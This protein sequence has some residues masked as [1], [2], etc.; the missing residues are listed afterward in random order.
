MA[1]YLLFLCFFIQKSLLAQTLTGVVSDARQRPLE[2]AV[3]SLIRASDSTFVKA[4]VTE[5]NGKFEFL[6]IKNGQYR[7]VATNVGF[8]RYKSEVIS[9]ENNDVTL[10]PI[11][12]AEQTKTLQEVTVTARKPFVEQKI[13]RMV[14]N[15][16]ALISNAGVSAL[17]VL[18]K[19]PG[20]LID[21]N[22]NISFK[23]K[24]GVMVFID[25]KPSYLSP[26]DLATYLRSLP[27]GSI[28]SVE[29]MTNP[30]AK[31]D[32]AGNAGIINIKLKKDVVRGLNGGINTSFGQGRLSR[33][34]NSINFNYRLNKIN[35]F[36]TASLNFNKVYQDLTIWREFFKPTGEFNSAFTQNSII[37]KDVNSLNLK[38]GA[39]IY[40]SKKLTL[41]V[42]IT[43]FRNP[44]TSTVDNSAQSTDNQRNTLLRNQA[45][46]NADKVL[47]NGGVNLNFTYK[48]DSLG[49]ELA[50]NFDMIG[51]SG[52]LAQTLEN[53]NTFTNSPVVDK[54][55]LDSSLPSDINIRTAKLDYS[56]PF[57]S[58]WQFE[59]GL[60]TSD[61]ETKNVAAFF[62]VV[63]DVANPNYVFSNSFT[64]KEKIQ[65]GYV[66]FSRDFKKISIQAGLRLE[67]TDITGIQFGNPVVKD[68]SFTRN[69]TNFFPTFYLAYRLDSL[70]THQLGFSYGRRID[71][72][73]YASMNPFTYPLDR[74]TLYGG[75][76][77]LRP[78]FSSNFE[79]S[80]TYK[81]RI[82]TTLGYSFTEDLISETI[83]QGSNIFYSRPGNFGRNYRY[84]LSVNG[85]IQPAKWLTF[86]FYG[87]AVHTTF[88]SLLYGQTLDLSR[89]YTFIQP[90][91]LFT[92]NPKWNAELGGNYLTRA[93]SGQFIIIP[94]GQMRVGIAK[95]ILNN[96]GTLKLNISDILYTNQPGG[97]IKGLANST[98]RWYSL[99]DTRVATLS[100][101]YRFNKGQNLKV[102]QS[103]ASETEQN[104]VKG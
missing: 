11:V 19:S 10:P 85:M 104:R 40:A 12:L 67:N 41:G 79:V 103:G 58:G 44:S 42:V 76:P 21:E 95:K 7:L 37:R 57:K 82:T 102:R 69:F 23:G 80:H 61:V 35:F 14:I 29:L 78:T 54:T 48:L 63:N 56:K 59:T 93:L 86:Q 31:Y 27:S 50:G 60:K 45:F 46:T 2:G 13:D 55:F 91:L 88:R 101:S 72:P 87:E 51:Y 62:D 65:A 90:T 71:R 15:P 34:T 20:V 33:N 77:F 1:R 43:G 53:T 25:D 75:N 8:G 64:Y 5:A 49:S 84:V 83:E 100:F 38:I 3:V 70:S 30:P 32:A 4:S 39:D 18:E 98:A 96:K 92:I 22:G 6:K 9:I 81:N 97:D 52:T 36:S 74:F 16:E 17:E 89:F 28:E 66:N 26:A 94:Y 99:L 24:Q 68:S 47:R 73:D